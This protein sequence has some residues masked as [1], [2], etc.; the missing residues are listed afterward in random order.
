MESNRSNILRGFILAA[1]A[2]GSMMHS[3]PSVGLSTTTVY[4]D[5]GNWGCIGACGGWGD[6]GFPDYGDPGWDPGGGGSGGGTVSVDATQ[7]AE[8]VTCNSEDVVKIGNAQYV[9][10][11][12]G[13]A[14]GPGD[15]GE[16]ITIRWS[17]GTVETYISTGQVG[18]GWMVPVPGT[19]SDA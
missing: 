14:P 11:N 17:T 5:P 15:R 7:G 13:L 16:T 19:C 8:A 18:T 6:P 9:A 12:N 3:D 10:A 2:G 4:G 1:L